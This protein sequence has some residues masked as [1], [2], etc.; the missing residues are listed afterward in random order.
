MLRKHS[1]TEVVLWDRI[2][3]YSPGW[4]WTHYILASVS[5][6]F[7][8]GVFYDKCELSPLVLTVSYTNITLLFF[9]KHFVMGL[10]KYP[11]S[12]YW[13]VP[14]FLSKFLYNLTHSFFWMIATGLLF[15]RSLE[16][17]TRFWLLYCKLLY[18]FWV[19]STWAFFH[20]LI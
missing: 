11:P 2:S 12:R 3:M 7:F 1:T 9:L 17:P 15:S 20:L 19:T 4:F 6:A 5:G 8:M 10:E 13:L 16:V 18:K 14:S